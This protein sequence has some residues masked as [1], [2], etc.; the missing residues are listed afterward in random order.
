MSVT[1]ADPLVAAD[2]AAATGNRRQQSSTR[3]TGV[4]HISQQVINND[5]RE[6]ECAV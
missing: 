2:A 4:S 6:S 3:A 1:A 5:A